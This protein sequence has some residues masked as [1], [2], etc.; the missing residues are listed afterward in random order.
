MANKN[1]LKSKTFTFTLGITRNKE[2][3]NE[4]TST[5]MKISRK[6]FFICHSNPHKELQL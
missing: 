4:H 5:C 6:T 3:I 1:D 2:T